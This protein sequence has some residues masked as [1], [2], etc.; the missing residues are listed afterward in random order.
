[1]YSAKYPIWGLRQLLNACAIYKIALPVSEAV[2]STAIRM[3]RA[4]DSNFMRYQSTMLATDDVELSELQ[5]IP[6][7]IDFLLDNKIMVRPSSEKSKNGV[8]AR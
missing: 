8:N 5:H 2:L 4:Y 6:E 3:Y 1:M 7:A